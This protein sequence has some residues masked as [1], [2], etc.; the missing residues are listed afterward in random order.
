[1]SKKDHAPAA[2]LPRPTSRAAR[3]DAALCHRRGTRTLRSRLHRRRRRGERSDGSPVRRSARNEGGQ[4]RPLRRRHR[5][6]DASA[7]AAKAD[8]DRLA[9]HARATPNPPSAYATASATR[10]SRR[11]REA[12]TRR[13]SAPSAS[14]QHR[15]PVELLMSEDALPERFLR[16]EPALE[17]ANSPT[18]SKRA[19][20]KR[21]PSPGSAKRATTYASRD[22]QRP[23]LLD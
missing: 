4:N 9:I 22:H 8:A 7:S 5:P 17:C 1:M 18:R 19:T 13:R 2:A 20:P 3:A 16:V 21:S 14:A 12:R 11:R 23:G 10:C 6:M 15:R